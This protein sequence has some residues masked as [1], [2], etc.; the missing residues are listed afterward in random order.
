[1]K[2]ALARFS[3]LAAFM[4]IWVST[5]M[6]SRDLSLLCSGQEGTVCN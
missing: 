1:M 4:Q 2:I 6:S 3:P 5:Y